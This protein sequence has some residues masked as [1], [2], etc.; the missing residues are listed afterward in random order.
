MNVLFAANDSIIEGLELAIWTLL[1]YNKH[2]NIYVATMTIIQH[3][4]EHH[5]EYHAIHQEQKDW[6]T[7]IVKYLDSNSNICFIDCAELYHKYIEGGV[8]DINGF[9]PYAA[10]R[11]LADVMLPDIDTILY[12]DADVAVQGNLESMYMQ[13]SIYSDCQYAIS[14]CYDAFDGK[15]EDV[16]GVLLMNL[17]RMRATGFLQ[18]ARDLYKKNKYKYPDQMAIRDA[19]PGLRL[20]ETYGY[21]NPLE[22][23]PYDPLILHFTCKLSPKI[24]CK[25]RP[26][27]IEYFYKRYP[28]FKYVQEGL[29]RLKTFPIYL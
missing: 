27:H 22:E 28:Q 2:V 14:C 16:T 5:L 17:N 23:A 20:P 8:N 6:L 29:E 18:K 7:K 12:L 4:D 3:V 13:Y 21:M 19:G 11:L 15:G 10:L 24:Y 25:D 26:N 9:T 1:K